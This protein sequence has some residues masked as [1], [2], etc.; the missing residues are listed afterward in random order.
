MLGWYYEK[1]GIEHSAVYHHQLAQILLMAPDDIDWQ[2]PV[3][4]E[5]VESS[6]QKRQ[7]SGYEAY[8]DSMAEWLNSPEAAWLYFY[9]GE[10]V[11]HVNGIGLTP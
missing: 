1:E 2:T 8:V 4:K 9:V 6:C 5:M 7:V 3:T 11:R 10:T